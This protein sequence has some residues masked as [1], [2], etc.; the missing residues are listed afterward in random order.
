MAE[1]TNL[2]AILQDCVNFMDSPDESEAEAGSG[3]LPGEGL[4]NLIKRLKDFFPLF[5]RNSGA[6]VGNFYFFF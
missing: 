1:Q 5:R 4:V 2:S 6:V 3:N